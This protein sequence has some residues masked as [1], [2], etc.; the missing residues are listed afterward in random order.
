MEGLFSFQ[1]VYNDVYRYDISPPNNGWVSKW[2]AFA[3]STF[4]MMEMVIQD[5]R[6]RLR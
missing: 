2:A 4:A 5:G 3:T 6:E 1:M